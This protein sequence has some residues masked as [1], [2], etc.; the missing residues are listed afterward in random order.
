MI[1][2][3]CGVIFKDQGSFS[4]HVNSHDDEK[5]KKNCE[6]CDYVGNSK[7]LYQHRINAHDQ[8]QL[9]CKNCEKLFPIYFP[10]QSITRKIHTLGFTI[11]DLIRSDKSENICFKYLKLEQAGERV[12]NIW[13]T[14]KRSRF[15]A[16]KDSKINY[17]IHFLSMKILFMLTKKCL[18]K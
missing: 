5:A 11:P 8:K 1:C 9:C 4:R 16:I 3:T 13:N 18:I 17:I 2:P 12:H 7:N 15:F 6:L 10:N 14:L